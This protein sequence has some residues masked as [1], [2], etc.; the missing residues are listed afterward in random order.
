MHAKINTLAPHIPS[1]L[2]QE[3][4]RESKD[5]INAL[6]IGWSIVH[7]LRKD[8]DKLTIT[9]VGKYVMLLHNHVRFN[10]SL[11]NKS[12][13]KWITYNGSA[14]I[15]HGDAIVDKQQPL[16]GILLGNTFTDDEIKCMNTIE[17]VKLCD[18]YRGIIGELN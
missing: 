9:R 3:S 16:L 17:F 7:R 4:F 1:F 8:N 15:H 11:V 10:N 2:Q 5:L 13:R 18:V 12:A 6:A 14:N